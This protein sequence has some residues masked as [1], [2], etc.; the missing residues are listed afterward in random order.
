MAHVLDVA[1]Y[2]LE[3]QGQ[4][5]TLKLQ[6]LVYYVQAWAIAKGD[7]LFSDAIKAWALGPVV[8]ALFQASKGRRS[9]TLDD[10]DARAP[11]ALTE[12]Q[13]AHIDSVL[14]YY[15]NLPPAYLSKLTHFEN[16]W[17]E[18]RAEGEK[19][20]QDSPPIP[21]TAI[22]A[23]YSGRTP[24]DLEANYQMTV[25]RTVMKQH[26]KCLARLAL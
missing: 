5:T 17:L 12:Q 9:V 7:P 18:A 24:E 3:R 6:K 19:N 14:A 22:R 2:I 15:G 10:M 16:P 4:V 8:P 25:A 11:M 1:R 26:K 21:V 13:R 20:G 23:F